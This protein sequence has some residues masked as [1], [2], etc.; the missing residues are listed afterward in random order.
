MDLRK[1][2]F[3]T[4]SLA[5]LS[6]PA[7]AAKPDYSEVIRVSDSYSF[8]F[9]C[10]TVAGAP[11]H[12][13]IAS[14]V[15]S[16]CADFSTAQK[17]DEAAY[18]AKGVEIKAQ[19]NTALQLA[20]AEYKMAGETAKAEQ[21]KSAKEIKALERSDT[22]AL[23]ASDVRDAAD[24]AAWKKINARYFPEGLSFSVAP[25]IDGTQAGV[26]Q[27]LLVEPAYD[28]AYFGIPSFKTDAAG[29]FL[30]ENPDP[31]HKLCFT[32]GGDD[33]GKKDFLA[34]VVDLCSHSDPVYKQAIAAAEKTEADTKAADAVTDQNQKAADKAQDDAALK[35]G[36][37]EGD[38]WEI[39][40]QADVK[41][42]NDQYNA[43]KRAD[44]LG[45]AEK[46]E[47]WRTLVTTRAPKGVLVAFVLGSG[48]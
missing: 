14:K 10:A 7:L 47:A 40:N 13:P 6:A 2:A 19:Y 1:L 8:G 34:A 39:Q 3:A 22:A 46:D 43:D 42:D 24:R 27:V 30:T 16:A 37:N 5:A 18:D 45:Y 31:F 21:A 23:A 11:M 35:S 36:A 32:I 48:K 20:D 38:A 9:F 25:V 33:H 12:G 29:N 15:Q 44:L 28:G 4:T 41:A 26:D 17:T